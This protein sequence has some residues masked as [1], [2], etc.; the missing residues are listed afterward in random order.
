MQR[1]GVGSTLGKIHLKRDK[2]TA[3]IKNVIASS[4]E[5]ELKRDLRNK[6]FCL[7]IDESTD[8][9]V[10]K[11]LCILIRFFCDRTGSVETR[12]MALIPVKE[13]TAESIFSLIEKKLSVI[14]WE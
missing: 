8:I 12:F 10:H 6:K 9:S 3:L 5:Q 13:A 14:I 2:C 11:N 7:I 1:H 4:M